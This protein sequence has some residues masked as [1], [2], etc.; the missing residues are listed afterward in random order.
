LRQKLGAEFDA[1][2]YIV[3]QGQN[4]ESPQ[5]LFYFE[6]K[7]I[8]TSAAISLGAGELTVSN[9]NFVTTGPIS[10]RLGVGVITNYVLKED[11]DKILLE[12]PGSGKLELEYD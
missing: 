7:G 2:L 8:V 1:E 4:A 5:D 9:F 3:D 12:Q 11:T 6:F 10:P